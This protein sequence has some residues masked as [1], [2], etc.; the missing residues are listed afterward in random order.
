MPG[1]ELA[2]HRR[3]Q[4]AVRKDS[5]REV[6][7]RNGER[8]VP[9]QTAPGQRLV[10]EAARVTGLRDDEMPLGAVAAEPAIL[11]ERVSRAHGDHELLVVERPLDE[12]RGKVP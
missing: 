6:K 8:D 11:R 1:H 4:I 12:P 2:G 3:D 7:A 5:E 10:D 9:Y